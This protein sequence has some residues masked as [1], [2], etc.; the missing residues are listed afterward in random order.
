M[1]DLTRGLAAAALALAF[2]VLIAGRCRPAWYVAQCGVIALVA[3]SQAA[4]EPGIAAVVLVAQAAWLWAPLRDA[5]GAPTGPPVAMAGMGLLLVVVAAATAP[6]GATASLSLVLLGLLGATAQTGP[7]GV[8]CLLNGAE[9]ALLNVPGLALLA[10]ALAA[11]AVLVS[12]SGAMPV[13]RRR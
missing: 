1:A 9:L 11:L 10:V 7:F 3:L 5:A 6:I 4:V 12:G 2:G 13:R 8:L